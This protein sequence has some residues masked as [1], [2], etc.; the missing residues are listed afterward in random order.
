MLYKSIYCYSNASPCG[1]VGRVGVLS[2]KTD[3]QI[4]WP[5]CLQIE[6]PFRGRWLS[7]FPSLPLSLSAI[8][9]FSGKFQVSASH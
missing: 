9:V 4:L 3:L 1:C 7:L 2:A 5:V 6:E 8:S